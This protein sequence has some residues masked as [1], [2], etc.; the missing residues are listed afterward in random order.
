MEHLTAFNAGGVC[1]I[2]CEP[3]EGDKLR[4]FRTE[5]CFHAF[6]AACLGAWW[7]ACWLT[8]GIVT[9]VA[10]KSWQIELMSFS[11]YRERYRKLH[12]PWI[13][14]LVF[15]CFVVTNLVN[16]YA[17]PLA[18]YDGHSWA[19]INVYRHYPI[20]LLRARGGQQFVATT[21]V[22][23]LLTIVET[24]EGSWPTLLM[25]GMTLGVW[26]NRTHPP[27][28]RRR[29][30]RSRLPSGRPPLRRAA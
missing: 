6:H 1:P 13:T 12:H 11:S 28:Q 4:C 21:M 2:C 14:F 5:D 3:P 26:G 19:T 7:H 9:A 24:I 23:Y 18:N 22:W 15:L 27:R 8:I 25:L 10:I 20:G 16:Y 30:E 29:R 17:P